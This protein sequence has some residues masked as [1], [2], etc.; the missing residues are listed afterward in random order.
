MK[1]SEIYAKTG[2]P[3]IQTQR[4]SLAGYLKFK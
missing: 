2:A 4:N 3:R 1:M